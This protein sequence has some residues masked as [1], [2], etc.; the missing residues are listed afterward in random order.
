LLE[1][2]FD[3]GHAWDPDNRF[4]TFDELR[5]RLAMVLRGDKTTRTL[6]DFDAELDKKLHAEDRSYQLHQMRPVVAMVSQR[7]WQ[8]QAKENKRKAVS[9]KFARFGAVNNKTPTLSQGLAC[10]G[11]VT[12]SLIVGIRG[13]EPAILL[14]FCVAAKGLLCTLLGRADGGQSERLVLQAAGTQNLSLGWQELG[15]FDPAALDAT[16]LDEWFEEAVIEVADGLA[17]L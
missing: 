3:T 9:V 6:A 16:K 15:W 13:R 12:G 5:Q 8:W 2:F 11:M 1:L 7:L 17:K 14:R 10:V 4:Q